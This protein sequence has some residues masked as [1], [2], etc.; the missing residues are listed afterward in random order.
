MTGKLFISKNFDNV[1][2]QEDLKK[3]KQLIINVGLTNASTNSGIY[4][5]DLQTLGLEDSTR[6]DLNEKLQSQQFGLDPIL[7]FYNTKNKPSWFAS[8]LTV[9]YDTSSSRDVAERL[10][11]LMKLQTGINFLIQRGAGLGV[12]IDKRKVTFFIHYIK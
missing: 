7:F 5:V 10:A 12:D 6:L 9:F 3:R 2:E 11:A 8:R 4:F 1:V